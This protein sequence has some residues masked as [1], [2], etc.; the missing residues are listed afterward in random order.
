MAA[1]F[2]SS[3]LLVNLLFLIFSNILFARSW[4][5]FGYEDRFTN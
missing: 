2:F 4:F 3:L 1:A 5:Q